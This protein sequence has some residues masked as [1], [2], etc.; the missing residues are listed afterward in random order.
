MSVAIRPSR[1]DLTPT[2]SGK[3]EHGALVFSSAEIKKA[4]KYNLYTV[5]GSEAEASLLVTDVL[6]V[7]C[8]EKHLES[9]PPY[10]APAG[11]VCPTCSVPL[12]PPKS[13]KDAGTTLFNNLKGALAKVRLSPCGRLL[14]SELRL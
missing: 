7:D 2:S 8:L 4:F 6:H 13:I 9:F 10:T 1:P 14:E 3:L 11:F 5:R 12:W